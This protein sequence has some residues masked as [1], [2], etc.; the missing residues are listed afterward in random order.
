MRA[1]P[2]QNYISSQFIPKAQT[3]RLVNPEEG[4]KIAQTAKDWAKLYSK[5]YAFAAA[6]RS[7]HASL[8]ANSKPM[9]SK[10]NWLKNSNKCNQFVGDVLTQSGFKMPTHAMKDGSLHFVKAE[11]LPDYHKTFARLNDLKQVRAGD[12]MVIDYNGRGASSAHVEVITKNDL[13]NGTINAIGAHFDGAYE[14]EKSKYLQNAKYDPKIKA[15]NTESYR[16]FF[17]RAQ[18]ND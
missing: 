1:V 12:I 2:T 7:P 14:T 10:L 4:Q 5:D 13:I 3:L 17:L 8:S 16:V 15:W 9:L 11:D 6:P 18:L